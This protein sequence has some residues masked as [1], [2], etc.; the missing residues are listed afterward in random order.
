VVI[1]L[2]WEVTL[3]VESLLSDIVCPLAVTISPLLL[4]CEDDPRFC[5]F[6]LLEKE[7]KMC[8]SRG[9]LG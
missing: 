3:V 9:V 4:V 1:V 8:E 5:T 6:N 7:N 2:N